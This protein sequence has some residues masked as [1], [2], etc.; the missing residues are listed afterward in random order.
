MSLSRSFWQFSSSRT[1]VSGP[2]WV[3]SGLILC[4]ALLAACGGS[5][6]PATSSS[7]S[8]AP[9]S[10]APSPSVTA[11][12]ETNTPG[13]IPDTIAYV[14][15]VNAAGRYKFDHPEGWAQTGQGTAV[16][17]TD[18]LNGVSAEVSSSGAAPT[19]ASAQS[20]DVPML[21]ASQTAF[22]L[23][24]VKAAT[25][26]AGPGVLI[27]YRRNSAPDAVTG[28]SVRVE[29]QRYEIYGHG[30]VV[31]LELFGAVGADNVD[32]YRNMS[33]SFALS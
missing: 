20:V 26:P 32:P 23:R 19:T 2:T 1:R 29:V 18:K 13:D 30:H 5:S 7:T 8:T 16:T 14:P 22:E 27:V 12:P 31:T 6:S 3:T 15:Y 17:F 24:A 10:T 28:K 11:A 9:H 33:Q 21:R 4:G 25:L